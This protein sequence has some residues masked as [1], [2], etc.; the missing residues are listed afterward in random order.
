MRASLDC[1]RASRRLCAVLLC[2]VSIAIEGTRAVWIQQGGNEPQTQRQT[3]PVSEQMG[4]AKVKAAAW[5][6]ELCFK[7]EAKVTKRE[8][9]HEN[10]PVVEVSVALETRKRDARKGGGDDGEWSAP[11]N[12]TLRVVFATNS[13]LVAPHEVVEPVCGLKTMRVVLPPEGLLGGVTARVRV[14]HVDGEGLR[15]PPKPKHFPENLWPA[16]GSKGDGPYVYNLGATFPGKLRAPEEY[17]APDETLLW[18][19]ADAVTEGTQRRRAGDANGRKGLPRCKSADAPGRWVLRRT[20]YSHFARSPLEWRPFGCRHA[21]V[22]GEKLATC[23]EHKLGGVRFAGE[24]TLGEIYE[25]WLTH[26]NTSN[27]YWQTHF[28][29]DA[30]RKYPRLDVMRGQGE[31]SE[32]HGMPF[33]LGGADGSTGLLH[34]LKEHPAETLI[35]LE[36][37]ND[38]A[39]FNL[40]DFGPRVEKLL[41]GLAK[42]REDGWLR[43]R[44]LVWVTAPTRLYKPVAGPGISQCDGEGCWMVRDFE[45]AD[46]GGSTLWFSTVSPPNMYP[47]RFYGTV[48]RREALNA[49][50]VQLVRDYGSQV[51]DEVHVVDYEA[52]TA[53]LPSDYNYDG[54][55]WGCRYLTYHDRWMSPYQCVGIA[56]V[57]V[58]NAIA[59]VLGC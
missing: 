20:L 23:L 41:N 15:D 5:E 3:I 35:V 25:A 40:T 42:A 8:M 58:A 1:S 7:G 44:R 31:H 32:F 9:E 22:T 24:S 19:T 13:A 34:E 2:V 28:P 37:A 4:C 21:R 52:M 12:D 10:A 39:R 48:A 55:H 49:R 47:P 56:N 53:A 38:A 59:S 11:C 6:R 18:D 27:Y 43:L 33:L 51:A 54:E 45:E 16:D 57:V 26:V 36:G 50:A 14:I 46:A 30:R 29:K 17:A